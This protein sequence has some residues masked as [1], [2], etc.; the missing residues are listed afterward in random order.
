MVRRA[1]VTGIG[2][3]T[4][5]G[6]H[7][8]QSAASIRAGLSAFREWP[9]FGSQIGEDGGIVAA[10]L[11]PDMGDVPW[12]EKALD[13]LQPALREALWSSQLWDLPQRQAAVRGFIAAPYPDR[14]GATAEEFQE[15]AA[16]LGEDWFGDESEIKTDVIA[17]E[18]AAG[19]VAIARAVDLL[20]AENAEVCVVGGVDS[21]LESTFLEALFAA[22]RLKA[23][24]RPS[25]L[26]PGEAAAVVV[27]EDEGSA[28]R[29]KVKPLCII[30]T[31]ALERDAPYQPEAPIK[32]DG[33]TRAIRS[34]LEHTRVSEVR[35]V[36][37]DLN[38]ERWRFQEWATAE[39]RCL[40][41]LPHGWQLWHPADCVGD[42][43]AAFGPL[44]VAL[45]TRAFARGYDGRGKVL[46]T[47]SSER[48]ERAAMSLAG[49]SQEEIH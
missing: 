27:L 43:G 14:E 12:M 31:V 33:L 49:P 17:L 29:R 20:A 41:G 7:A 16:A 26:I 25:G 24:D 19:M 4:P 18:Q 11:T 46:I 10:Y 23:G 45:A 21:L 40:D 35:R 48:G 34:V 28:R 3:R 2:L 44:A 15:N 30:E 22:G 6:L 36:L 13:L 38:G 5:L 32:A 42:T 39:T 1:A 47:A 8:A 9:H 37:T